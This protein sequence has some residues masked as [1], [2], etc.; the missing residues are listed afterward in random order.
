MVLLMFVIL[1]AVGPKKILMIMKDSA[2]G[3][4]GAMV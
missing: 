3:A 4:Y 2:I 1:E